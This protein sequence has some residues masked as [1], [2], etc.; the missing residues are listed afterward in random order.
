MSWREPNLQEHPGGLSS[1]YNI[2]PG[3]DAVGLIYPHQWTG[4]SRAIV[5]VNRMLYLSV[6]TSIFSA[7][8]ALLAKL[9]INR[10]VAARVRGSGADR[11]R[12]LQLK[13]DGIVAREFNTVVGSLSRMLQISLW[14]LACALPL[15]LWHL[16]SDFSVWATTFSFFFHVFMSVYEGPQY[17]GVWDVHYILGGSPGDIFAGFSARLRCLIHRSHFKNAL[18]SRE[19]GTGRFLLLPFAFVVDYY[20]VARYLS[21]FLCRS[22]KA[23]VLH[24]HICGL[25]ILCC[26]WDVS[27]DCVRALIQYVGRG[28]GE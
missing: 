14:L 12:E 23:F 17:Q 9:W 27:G 24:V 1:H 28:R 21:L 6:A 11:G 19:K 5:L 3:S 13:P 20:H 18:W 7:F 8:I 15:C 22:T 10:Y 4:P 25:W 2:A 26:L 16:P